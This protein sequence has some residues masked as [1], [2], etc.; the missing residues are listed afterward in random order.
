MN[1]K[2]IT[3]KVSLTLRKH[4]PEILGTMGMLATVGG[5]VWAC[6]ATVDAADDIKECQQDVAEIKNAVKEEIIEKKEGNKQIW[7]AR[8]ECVKKVGVKYVG[9]VVLVGGGLYCQ[10]KSASLLT[11]RLNGLAAAYTALEGRY[12]LLEDNIRRD[13][14]EDELNR[15][16]YGLGSQK[17]IVKLVDKDGNEVEGEETVTGVLN[18][19]DVK[20]FTIVFDNRSGRHHTS[21]YHCEQELTSM[22]KSLTDWL[23]INKVIWLDWAMAQLDIYPETKEEAQA[24]HSICWVYKPGEE[25]HDNEVKLRWRQVIEPGAT[26]FDIDYNPVYILDPN[27]DTNVTQDWYQPRH[28]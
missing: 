4:A 27:Y 13:Y 10:H 17:G 2:N 5:I 7:K 12:R 1:F 20:P 26:Q 8:V 3:N 18:L 6:K 28:K 15:L 9:P 19:N 24:W 11:K 16:K 21:K 25:G 14:G 23:R 22:E